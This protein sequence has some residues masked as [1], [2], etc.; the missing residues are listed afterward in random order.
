MI[1]ISRLRGT[2]SVIRNGWLSS[3]EAS[4]VWRAE[5][6]K[7]TPGPP[8]EE[9]RGLY[10]PKPTDH[11]RQN[12]AAMAALTPV[13]LP[14]RHYTRVC[15]PRI[16]LISHLCTQR[17]AHRGTSHDRKR[18]TTNSVCVA[19]GGGGRSCPPAAGSN[20]KDLL[21]W[22]KIQSYCP[23][24]LCLNFP[25]FHVYTHTHIHKGCTSRRSKE[26]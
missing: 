8:Q 1:I 26:K 25:L 6:G 11:E 20:H 9:V 14:C 22:L 24:C 4:H 5:T 10:Q 16:G 2:G 12:R 15:A 21:K 7:T 18:W 19:R 17:W 13:D 23:I 3:A